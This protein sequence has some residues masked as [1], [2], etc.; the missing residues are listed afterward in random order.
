[1]TAISPNLDIQ[2]ISEFGTSIILNAVNLLI[3]G[4]L[5]GIYIVLFCAAAAV[6]CRREGNVKARAALLVAIVTMFI[7]SSFDFWSNVTIFFASIQ[8]IF[9]GNVGQPFEHKRVVFSRR[10]NNLDSVKQVILPLE[11]VVGDSIVIWRAWA[12]SGGNRKIVVIPLLLLIGS[13][14]C[15]FAFLGCFAQNDW[16]IVNPDTCNSIEISAFSLSIATNTS[17]TIIIGYKFWRYRQAVGR[18]LSTCYANRQPRVGKILILL[19]ESGIIYSVLWIVQLVEI[20]LPPPPTFPGQVVQQ[21]FI[22][23]SVQ[24]MGIYPALLIVLV[25]L[26]RTMWDSYGIS[27]LEADLE[28]GG[29]RSTLEVGKVVWANH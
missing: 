7:M 5:Y 6:L 26:Q 19:L 10:F 3:G 27:T 25:Y 18:F 11:I 21:I 29:S 17:A 2:F 9:V 22:A 8:D 23:A 12:L 20:L 16:P 1:M 4:I 28:R 14:G 15:S 13:A 24:L